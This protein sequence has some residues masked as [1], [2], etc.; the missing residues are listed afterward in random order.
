MRA[1]TVEAERLVAVVA[2]HHEQVGE[3][4]GDDPADHRFAAL[5]NLLA[6][7]VPAA[8]LV[9]ER[10]ELP[11]LLAAAHARAAVV[12]Q[13]LLASSLVPLLLIAPIGIGIA[14]SEICNGLACPRSAPRTLLVALIL[15]LAFARLP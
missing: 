6:M 14:L 1:V 10:Q 15:Y 13:Y 5:L 8:V 12:V 9:I 7:D 4:V 11:T 3:V 2:T